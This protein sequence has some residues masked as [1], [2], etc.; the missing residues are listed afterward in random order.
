MTTEKVFCVLG[1]CDRRI[2]IHFY[3]GARVLLLAAPGNEVA[4]RLVGQT[5]EV[6]GENLSCMGNIIA[7]MV[8]SEIALL[9]QPEVRALFPM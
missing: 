5:I 8:F 9:D 1:G 4:Y 7:R 6:T 3:S 2:A